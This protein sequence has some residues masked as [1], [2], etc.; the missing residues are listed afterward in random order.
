MI[1]QFEIAWS[2]NCVKGTETRFRLYVKVGEEW[3]LIK[4]MDSRCVG[5]KEGSQSF[6]EVVE[7]DAP[8]GKEFTLG[9]TAINATGESEKTEYPVYIPI[10]DPDPPENFAVT[11]L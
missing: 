9:L 10:P 8:V 7:H 6:T 5:N 1:K 4:E 3:K 11:I 2:Y